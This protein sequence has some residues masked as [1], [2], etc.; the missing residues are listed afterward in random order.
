[1]TKQNSRTKELF[2][3]IVAEPENDLPRLIYADHLIELGD[4]HGELIQLQCT[5]K[6]RRVG[7]QGKEY[8]YLRSPEPT[9][10]EHLVLEK[11]ETVLLKKLQ[12]RLLAP[13][14][15]SIRSWSFKRGFVDNVEADAVA[16]IEGA[17]EIF[18][19]TPLLGA[20]LT[21]VNAD[22]LAALGK[23][24][25]IKARLREL[26][27]D[28]QSLKAADIHIHANSLFSGLEHLSLASNPLNRLG[29]EALAKC[30]L[31]LLRK[32]CLSGAAWKEQQR[33][34][35]IGLEALS[36]SPFFGA[37]TQLDIARNR[38][39]DVSL[40]PMLGR[41]KSLQTLVTALD[42]DGAVALAKTSTLK[43]LQNLYLNAYDIKSRGALALANSK[44]LSALQN[45]DGLIEDQ[46]AKVKAALKA[47]FRWLT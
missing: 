46:N 33:D 39:M 47:R 11:R 43:N 38:E 24:A 45:I 34:K 3:A 23:N 28:G 41:G 14:R 32:L 40:V 22:A 42:D 8:H 21:R 13:F 12:K 30:H 27:L 26:D 4:E 10:P 18:K 7:A 1:M 31:P 2:A 44:T 5:L 37:L 29:F 16:F 6:K 17:S 15:S 25:L 19:H 20:K 35:M 9:S 36:K